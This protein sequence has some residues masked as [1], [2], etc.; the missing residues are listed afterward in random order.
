[1]CEARA[2]CCCAFCAYCCCACC[3][4]CCAACCCCC[5]CCC[6]GC[7]VC[8]CTCCACCCACCCA[9]CCAA[10]CDAC[11]CCCCAGCCVGCCVACCC[12]CDAC[13]CCC[14]VGACVGCCCAC[15]CACWAAW[16]RST[17]PSD[18]RTSPL[19]DLNDGAECVNSLKHCSAPAPAAPAAPPAAAPAHTQGM[20]LYQPGAWAVHGGPSQSEKHRTAMH[21][22][23]LQCCRGRYRCRF[24]LKAARLAA[25]QG[26]KYDAVISDLG[27]P[28]THAAQ[29]HS[30]G[31]RPATPTPG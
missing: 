28:C 26:S 15:C 4:C 25:W 29:A 31:G 6:V 24:P 7:C 27:V 16:E 12:A 3:A 19:H 11:C 10:C 22:R 2:C 13:C 8:C 30:A 21:A 14:C 20:L 1:M 9:A 5:C 17:N 18:H 23:D